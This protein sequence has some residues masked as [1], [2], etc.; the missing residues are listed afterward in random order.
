MASMS[1]SCM[2]CAHCNGDKSV[3]SSV[4]PYFSCPARLRSKNALTTDATTV[5]SVN[6]VCVCDIFFALISGYT[7]LSCII[8]NALNYENSNNKKN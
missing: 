3:R 4:V 7:V 2:C 6:G 5:S 1:S 8:Y